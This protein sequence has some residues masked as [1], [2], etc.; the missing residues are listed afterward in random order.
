[1]RNI[2]QLSWGNYD[3]SL[4][5][6]FLAPEGVTFEQ[7]GL[8]C[9]ELVQVVVDKLVERQ[10]KLSIMKR[11]KVR[12]D[13]IVQELC[14]VL[15]KSGF[16]QVNFPTYELQLGE[17]EYDVGEDGHITCLG[18]DVLK[19]VVDYNVDLHDRLFKLGDY[20]HEGHD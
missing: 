2:Y 18:K 5:N 11:V 15:V 1:M 9:A 4:E 7:F 16:E 6:Y 12:G 3:Y 14:K 13:L 10:K 8:K 19:K 17:I 20:A